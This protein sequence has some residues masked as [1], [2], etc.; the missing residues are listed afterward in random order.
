MESLF[1]ISARVARQLPEE[2][3][4]ALAYILPQAKLYDQPI[5]ITDVPVTRYTGRFVAFDPYKR[6]FLFGNVSYILHD[7]RLEPRD[8]RFNGSA[9]TIDEM[10]WY[11]EQDPFHVLYSEYL[12]RISLNWVAKY[13]LALDVP[14]TEELKSRSIPIQQPLPTY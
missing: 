2:D 10:I 11:Q 4:L 13:R 14:D 8:Y 9:L 6:V 5:F 1:E 3:K 12:I 7:D